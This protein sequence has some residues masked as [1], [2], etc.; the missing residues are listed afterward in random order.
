MARI[1][2]NADAAA[3]TSFGVFSHES[4]VSV[5]KISIPA[6]SKDKQNDTIKAPYVFAPRLC[7][8]SFAATPLEIMLVKPAGMNAASVTV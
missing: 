4:R 2:V 8:L 7:L 1:L 5:C 6:T 3:I